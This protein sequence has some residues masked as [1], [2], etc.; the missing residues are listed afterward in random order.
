MSWSPRT[1][2]PYTSP[3]SSTILSTTPSHPDLSPEGRA[4][5]DNAI[6]KGPPEVTRHFW[7][8]PFG[9]I[10]LRSWPAISEGNRVYLTL[11]SAWNPGFLTAP[12]SLSLWWLP[13][14]TLEGMGPLGTAVSSECKK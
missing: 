2:F 7:G 13:S 14:E 11:R 4:Q 9:Q 10:V 5:R 8:P 1:P 6:H 12:L 3:C